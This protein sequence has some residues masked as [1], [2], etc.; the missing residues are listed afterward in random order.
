M[1][2]H[3]GVKSFRLLSHALHALLAGTPGSPE[4]FLAG[5]T[6]RMLGMQDDNLLLRYFQVFKSIELVNDLLIKSVEPI[7]ALITRCFICAGNKK[8]A[9]FTPH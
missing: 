7:T 4:S 3:P 8:L 9:K 2:R 6:C 1:L 5:V